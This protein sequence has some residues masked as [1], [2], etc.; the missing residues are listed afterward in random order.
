MRKRLELNSK[1]DHRRS[2]AYVASIKTYNQ[3]KS[4]IPEHVQH[5]TRDSIAPGPWHIRS[6]RYI[7]YKTNNDMAGIPTGRVYVERLRP[8]SLIYPNSILLVQRKHHSSDVKVTV[9]N[10]PFFV[11]S[12]SAP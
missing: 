4:A 3:I 11:I 9:I 8:R 1:S 5:H 12:L 6:A 10:T 7:S 2:Q